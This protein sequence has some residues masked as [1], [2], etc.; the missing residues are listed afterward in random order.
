MSSLCHWL[1]HDSDSNYH[2]IPPFCGGSHAGLPV[3]VIYEEFVLSRHR[4]ATSFID[5]DF[6]LLPEW[7]C[8]L[9]PPEDRYRAWRKMHCN[10]GRPNSYSA[11]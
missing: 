11:S 7:R 5:S 3:T 1:C 9:E 10:T 2:S 6:N 8:E 4:S